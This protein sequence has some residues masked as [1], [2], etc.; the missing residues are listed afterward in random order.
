MLTTTYRNLKNMHIIVKSLKTVLGEGIIYRALRVLYRQGPFTFLNNSKNY[1]Y[2]RLSTKFHFGLKFFPYS[3]IEVQPRIFN[4]PKVLPKISIIAILYNKKNEVIYFLESIFNQAYSGEIEIVLIDDQSP[5]SD[6]ATAQKA[7]TKLQKNCHKKINLKIIKNEKN[8]GNCI[9]RNEGVKH[10]TG[11]LIII[12]DADSYLNPE[13]IEAHVESHYTYNFDV[14]IGPMNIETHG[15]TPQK[16]AK[17][18]AENHIKL[19]SKMELQDSINVNNFL[20]CIT[21]N[22]SIK[23]SLI[24]EDLFDP[25]FSYSKD[26]DSGFGW[27]DV[28]MGYRLYKRGLKVQFLNKS[29]SMHITHPSSIPD[30]Q[31]VIKSLINLNKLFTKHPDFLNTARIWSNDLVTK[32]DQWYKNHHEISDNKHY[33]TFIELTSPIKRNKIKPTKRM[34]NILT[35]RW[36]VPHQYELYKTNHRFTLVKDIC[37]GFTNVWSYEQRPFP[38]NARFLDLDKINFSEYDMALL[39]FDENAL[40]WQNCNGV[41][42]QYWGANFR[43]FMENVPLPKIA[44]CHGTPQFYG[45]YNNDTVDPKIRYS[46]IEES[47]KKLVDYTKNIKVICNS[48]QAHSEWGFNNSKVIWQG[49]DPCEYPESTYEKGIIS[50][51]KAMK[52]RPHYRGYEIYNAVFEKISEKNHPTEFKVQEPFQR[53]FDNNYALAKYYEYVNEIR[54]HSIYFNPTIRSPM[55]RSRGEAMM[56]GLSTVSL[57]NHDVN[58]FIKNGVNG[59]YSNNIEELAEYLKFLLNNPAACKSIGKEARKTSMDL[60]NIDRYLYEWQRNFDELN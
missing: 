53:V 7:F 21:R 17:E 36:H 58:L 32:I 10:S 33:Q 23:K 14:G 19:F 16:L 48:N 35:Y 54:K 57:N 12:V 31:K 27:E 34:Y 5:S 37:P 15:K 42:D 22:F 38:S 49:F 2:F 55:P 20:N 41:L 45:Q 11:D 51:G 60:F 1:I 29:F 25:Q 24:T 46:V 13:Y 28:E 47:R 56:C 40:D 8:K 18:L 52:E 3:T 6:A 4:L 44:I 30:N 59:F 9:S 39:H 50:L 26:P 43:Y